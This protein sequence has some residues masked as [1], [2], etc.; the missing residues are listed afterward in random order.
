M[1]QALPLDVRRASVQPVLLCL[2][3]H[4]AP[5][6][7]ARLFARHIGRLVSLAARLPDPHVAM[8]LVP[9]ISAFTILEAMYRLDV[10]L[11]CLVV[12][13]W[14]KVQGRDI[15]WCGLH[16]RLSDGHPHFG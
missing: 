1:P 15:I 16:I 14:A 13:H 10:P 12:T 9:C 11:R 5:P 3:P 4:C 6:D 8:A 7:A 2:V